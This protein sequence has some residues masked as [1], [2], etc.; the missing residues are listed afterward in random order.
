MSGGRRR[1]VP[2]R[3]QCAAADE[4]R[5]Q[6][7]IHPPAAMADTQFPLPR[8]TRRPACSSGVNADFSPGALVNPFRNIAG[9]KFPGR[10][11]EHPPRVQQIV[12]QGRGLAADVAGATQPVQHLTDHPPR[13]QVRRRSGDGNAGHHR[14][15]LLRF[16]RPDRIPE[17][18]LHAGCAEER[19]SPDSC[20]I[21]ARQRR[22]RVRGLRGVGTRA[23][24]PGR[25]ARLLLPE[26]MSRR[27]STM[28]GSTGSR[29][30]P[31]ELTTSRAAP[32]GSCPPRSHC[33]EPWTETTR[34]PATAS[35]IAALREEL[36]ILLEQAD[37]QP[38]D[39]QGRWQ[40]HAQ[41]EKCEST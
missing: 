20:V 3:C 21:R 26:A 9:G 23:P 40:D 41:E 29:V 36:A 22:S 10:P 28:R 32:R 14:K 35:A 8:N 19:A 31:A 5:R 33:S 15:L 24:R 37:A 25:I 2:S 11:I 16:E 18:S 1:V 38:H 39:R 27:T 17:R 12:P 7:R 34:E 30:T 4:F 6:I 13:H